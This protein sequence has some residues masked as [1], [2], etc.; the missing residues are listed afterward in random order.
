MKSLDQKKQGYKDRFRCPCLLS[1]R[2]ASQI[3]KISYL[4]E[5]LY[6]LRML[7]AWIDFFD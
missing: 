4:V 7:S 1:L 5:F 6:K 3:L 2:A